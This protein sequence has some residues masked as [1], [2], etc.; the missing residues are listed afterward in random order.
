MTECRQYPTRSVAAEGRGCGR[1]EVC[2]R[3]SPPR[4]KP[5]QCI[6]SEALVSK[7]THLI[8]GGACLLEQSL[9]IFSVF[10]SRAQ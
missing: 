5:V 2:V 7:S 8:K 1:R 9:I 10:G 4:F 6:T 3:V